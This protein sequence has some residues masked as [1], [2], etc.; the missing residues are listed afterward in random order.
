M[1]KT[2][3]YYLTKRA[4]TELVKVT[5]VNETTCTVVYVGQ[6]HLGECPLTT[7]LIIDKPI[8]GVDLLSLWF[9]I[10]LSRFSLL[11]DKQVRTLNKNYG[12]I[13]I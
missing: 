5:K 7:D 11:L 13:S 4:V 6:E 10:K 9:D 3:K 2:E 8:E 12:T 1:I